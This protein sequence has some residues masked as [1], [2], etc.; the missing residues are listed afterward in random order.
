M[1]RLSLL[2]LA[3]ALSAAALAQDTSVVRDYPYALIPDG[4]RSLRTAIDPQLPGAIEDLQVGIYV[5]HPRRG[6]LEVRLTSPSGTTVELFDGSPR[7]GRANL[8]GVF[9]L[10]LASEGDLGAFKG[11]DFMGEWT[12]EVSDTR[13]GGAGALVVWSLHAT[14]GAG[15]PPTP[16]G[17]RFEV[18]VEN[19]S[20]ESAFPTPLAPGAWA[21]HRG[22]TPLAAPGMEGL[23]E[24]GNPVDL[25][26]SLAR[27]PGV[28]AHG[29]FN[30]PDGAN[31]PGP[32]LPAGSYRFTVEAQ[33]GDRLSLATMLGQTNDTI[34]GDLRG[35]ALFDAQGRPFDGAVDSL[36]VYDAGTEANEAPGL[37]PNQAPRQ[38]GPNTGG[39]ESSVRP[40]TDTTRALPLTSDL[41]EVRV[42][43]VRGGYTIRLTNQ[44][45]ALTSPLTPVLYATHAEGFELFELDHPAPPGLEQLAED[46]DTVFLE[47][48]LAANPLVRSTAVAGS[49]P[50]GPGAYVELEVRADR[51]A[52]RLSLATMIART[53]DAFVSTGPQ[54]VSLYDARGGLLDADALQLALEN[55]LHVYDAGTE[56][57]E[58][59]GVGPNIAPLQ[60]GPNTGARDANPNVRRYD[61]SAN[62]FARGWARVEVRD[63]DGR[64]TFEVTIHNTSDRTGY[65]GRLSR[66]VYGLDDGSG[67]FFR[68]GRRASQGLAAL[69][70]EGQTDGYLAELN[71]AGVGSTGV[72]RSGIAPGGSVSFRVQATRRNRFLNLATMVVPS[73]D[74]FLALGERG[75]ALATS[76]GRIRSSAAIQ[77]D[78][79]AMAGIWDAGSEANEAGAAGVTQPP[80]VHDA[81]PAEGSGRLRVYDDAVWELPSAERMVRVRIRPLR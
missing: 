70:E 4:A 24:D 74:A 47:Q 81:G 28:S 5:Y 57:N 29:V 56:A 41:V 75:V 60:A 7:D 42:T 53:N 79:D 36:R 9:G 21:L 48:Q 38:A 71:R 8:G 30:T 63:V 2:L 69:A 58:A 6:D 22:G 73:N 80:A 54:G 25:D 14:L 1:N 39:A 34:V 68:S 61:D 40:F 31:M 12:L 62:D 76:G 11:E 66:A 52:P 65:P 13:R 16:T 45:H 46:G 10:N 20:G 49:G 17:Q 37:G 26:L 19:V 77:R 23:A 44:S 3:S 43:R 32:A 55:A 15:L 59:P 50:W 33:P 51:R 18:I 78:L 64:G 27:D 67:R 72:A 35:I